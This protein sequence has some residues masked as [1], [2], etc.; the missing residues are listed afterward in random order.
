MAEK[1]PSGFNR[2][3][4]L[5]GL[6]SATA[7]ASISPAQATEVIRIGPRQRLESD[8]EAWNVGLI[9]AHRPEL[10]F[11]EN[12]G[13]SAVLQDEI[14][15]G[16]FGLLHCRGQ[17]IPSAGVAHAFLVIGSADDSGNLKGFLRK[18]GRKFNQDAVVWKGYY[19]DVLLF[20]LK[21]LP[22]MGMAD[23][24]VQSLGRYHPHRI[25]HY[26][27]RMTRPDWAGGTWDDFGIWTQP[28]FLNPESRRV[29][30]DDRGRE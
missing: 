20:A 2:R 16:G 14:R 17:Y 4:F 19:R 10:S 7:S 29:M 21:D 23:G 18:T 25:A 3:H 26:Y 1:Y 9:T 12:I 5:T 28:T 8:I 13:R 15:K 30:F 6:G 11:A 22:A 24:D 27:T